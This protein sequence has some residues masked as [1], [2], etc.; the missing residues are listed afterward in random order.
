MFFIYIYAVNII[1]YLFIHCP[2]F[3]ADELKTLFI[4]IQYI[5]KYRLLRNRVMC[6]FFFSSQKR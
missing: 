2:R 4:I 6:V 1:Y 5:Y 3:R